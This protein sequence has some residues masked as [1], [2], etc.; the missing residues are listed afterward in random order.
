MKEYD[1]RMKL[2]FSD[3]YLRLFILDFY[4]FFIFYLRL[5]LS[6]ITEQEDHANDRNSTLEVKLTLQSVGLLYIKEAVSFRLVF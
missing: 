2:K 3:F 1:L 4:L 6:R 5:L